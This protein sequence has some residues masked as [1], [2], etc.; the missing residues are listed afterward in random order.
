MFL[1]AHK[2]YFPLTKQLPIIIKNKNKK[3]NYYITIYIATYITPYN[4]IAT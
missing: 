3:T 2:L 1:L 4:H